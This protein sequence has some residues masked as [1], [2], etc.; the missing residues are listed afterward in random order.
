MV[1]EEFLHSSFATLQALKTSP[2]DNNLDEIP[3]IYQEYGIT[4]FYQALTGSAEGTLC[5]QYNSLVEALNKDNHLPE[6]ILL[7]PDRDIILELNYFAPGTLFILDQELQWLAKSLDRAITARREK[8]REICSGAVG[9]QPKLVWVQMIH[10]PFIK[11]HPYATYNL[12]VELRGKFNS[13]LEQEARKSMYALIIETQNHSADPEFF[14]STGNLTYHGK[15]AFWLH[16]DREIKCYE[17]SST[18]TLHPWIDNRT[19]TRETGQTFHTKKQNPHRSNQPTFQMRNP[20]W[21]HYRN[22]E[23]YNSRS[24]AHS[25]KTNIWG[26]AARVSAQL[27]FKHH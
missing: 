7:F 23:V 21:N 6:Y 8:L 25:S 20:L 10:R 15:V 3:Y 27:N 14:D 12:I 24:K 1:G 19:K 26:E 13:L 9:S 5:N 16:I 18:T 17:T 22:Q 2:S 11:N 4:P